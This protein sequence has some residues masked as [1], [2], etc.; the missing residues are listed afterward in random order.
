[1]GFTE[2][3]ARQA[4][5]YAMNGAMF[6][7]RAGDQLA[8]EIANGSP[9]TEEMPKLLQGMMMTREWIN[10]DSELVIKY[11]KRTIDGK[12]QYVFDR[13][14]IKVIPEPWNAIKVN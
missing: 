3:E 4:L 1:M 10:L 14:D 11:C 8:T 7:Y 2:E 12:H 6:M 13:G 9:I 5:T